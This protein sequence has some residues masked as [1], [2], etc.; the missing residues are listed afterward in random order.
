MKNRVE[1]PPRFR[2]FARATFP[3]LK[4][5]KRQCNLWETLDHASQLLRTWQLADVAVVGF[6]VMQ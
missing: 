4:Q 3:T 6:I 5:I 2:S 1:L